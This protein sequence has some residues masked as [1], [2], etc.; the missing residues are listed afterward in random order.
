MGPTVRA[1]VA[2]PRRHAVAAALALCPRDEWIG[3]DELFAKMRSAGASPTIAR[4][5]RGL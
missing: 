5:E 4:S 1:I 2:R 3:V